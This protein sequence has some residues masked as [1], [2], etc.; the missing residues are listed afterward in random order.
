MNPSK[1]V[2]EKVQKLTDLPNIGV[3][4]AKDLRSIGINTPDDL[5]GKDP[6]ELYKNLCEKTGARQD[7][8]VLDTFMSITDFMNGG[9]PKV[10]WEYTQKRKKESYGF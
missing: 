2:R 8:C 3:S 1:V 10:W 9:E 4:M 5:Q 6:F 7:P